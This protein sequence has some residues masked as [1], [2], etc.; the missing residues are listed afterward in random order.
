M[1]SSI[2]VG[3]MQTFIDYAEA[4]VIIMIIW[5]VI[6]FFMVSPPTKEERRASEEE[7]KQ[8]GAEWREQVKRKKKELAEKAAAQEQEAVK[9]R[10]VRRRKDHVRAPMSH[11]LH[12]RNKGHDVRHTLGSR[13]K[14]AHREHIRKKADSHLKDMKRQL[15]EAAGALQTILKKE[16]DSSLHNFFENMRDSTAA[17]LEQI[18]KTELPPHDA[19]NEEW[20]EGIRKARELIQKGSASC[21]AIHDVLHRWT[22]TAERQLLRV[23]EVPGAPVQ[24][25]EAGERRRGHR[26][27]VPRMQIRK[28]K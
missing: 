10:D 12:A 9:M 21:Q 18:E 24:R 28:R 3:T 17:V 11:L 14:P 19:D 13:Y 5:Y 8:R 6:K 26:G 16:K 27:P 20:K 25:G 1:V 7:W 23:E 2:I 4:V 15:E 22:Q